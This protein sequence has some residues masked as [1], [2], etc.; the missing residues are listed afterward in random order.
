MKMKRSLAIAIVV[1]LVALPVV[2]ADQFATFKEWAAANGVVTGSGE[3]QGDVLETFPADWA[4][5]PIGVATDHL[6]TSQMWFFHEAAPSASI[7]SVDVTAPRT[8]QALSYTKLGGPNVDGGSVRMSDGFIYACDFNGDLAEIDDNIYLFDRTGAT[9][10]FWETETGLAGTP[11]TGGFVHT[12][13]DVAADPSVVGTVYATDTSGNNITVLDLSNT[14]GGSSSPSPCSVLA[15]ISA[16]API[17][18]VLGIEY[19][20]Q[21]DGYWL[22]D[23]LS[24]N[25]VLVAADGTFNTVIESFTGDSGAGYNSGVSVQRMGGPP[26]PLWVTDFSSG[27]VT[28]LDSGTVPVEIQSFTIE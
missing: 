19:D 15:V 24:T 12:I 20:P 9:V 26:L 25:L 1:G 7:W 21:N 3:A 14:S 17:I 16:P 22:S 28:I 6:D 10:A 13:I 11:C 27:A 5:T 23:Y 4:G 2:A 18:N 8:P